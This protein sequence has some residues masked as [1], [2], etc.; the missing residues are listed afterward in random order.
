[1]TTKP[2]EAVA[3]LIVDE[4]TKKGLAPLEGV[5]V[6]AAQLAEGSVSAEDWTRLAEQRE[7]KQAKESRA[8]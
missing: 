6:F 4:L 2:D 7:D 8:H 5:T 1:M 3:A